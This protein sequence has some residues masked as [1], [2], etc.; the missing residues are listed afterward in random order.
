MIFN[1][2][3][4]W[5][6]VYTVTDKIVHRSAIGA[7]TSGLAQKLLYQTHIQVYTIKVYLN[8]NFCFLHTGQVDKLVMLTKCRKELKHFH[9]KTWSDLKPTARAKQTPKNWLRHHI[10]WFI[11]ASNKINQL[12]Q[13]PQL[14]AV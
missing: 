13:L 5:N 8:K 4:C 2:V 12:P 10:S 6:G 9:I 7:S 14:L 11:L 3:T 1:V